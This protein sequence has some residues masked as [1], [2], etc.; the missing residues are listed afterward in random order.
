MGQGSRCLDLARLRVTVPVTDHHDR[1]VAPGRDR[2]AARVIGQGVLELQNSQCLIK[3]KF[4]NLKYQI[5]E[6]VGNTISAL[7]FPDSST[8]SAIDTTESES[9]PPNHIRVSCSTLT[10]ALQV[11]R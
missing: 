1:Q 6:I 8:E 10:L 2:A 7:A 5:L 9:S 4:W 3:F 11:T